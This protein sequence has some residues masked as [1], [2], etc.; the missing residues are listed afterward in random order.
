MSPPQLATDT[1]ILNVPHPR[2][3][4]VFPLLR[5]KLDRPG[6]HRLNSGAC[7]FLCVDVPLERQPGFYNNP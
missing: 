7:K 1:P 2:V 5:H 6:L 3:I 4:R